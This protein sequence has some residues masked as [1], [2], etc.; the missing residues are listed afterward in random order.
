[1]AGSHRQFGQ[2]KA[3]VTQNPVTNI[4]RACPPML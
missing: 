1:M 2:R 4:F 3:A